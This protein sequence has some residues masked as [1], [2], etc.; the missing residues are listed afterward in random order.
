ME[1]A[2]SSSGRQRYVELVSPT[3]A[4]LIDAPV[5]ADLDTLRG[6]LRLE[7][8]VGSGLAVPDDPT[9]P[10]SEVIASGEQAWGRWT[11]ARSPYGICEA[12]TI[13]E[14]VVGVLVPTGSSA[15]LCTETPPLSP[16]ACH[17]LGPDRTVVALVGTDADNLTVSQLGQ[18]IEARFQSGTGGTAAL[19]THTPGQ[20]SGLSIQ[21]PN[22]SYEC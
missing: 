1:H 20:P 4:V 11:V 15:Y 17:E 10:A 2:R 16:L 3:D 21:T 13:T 14:W 7:T 8:I 18:P 5:D 12:I 22:A 19:I 9:V 6:S